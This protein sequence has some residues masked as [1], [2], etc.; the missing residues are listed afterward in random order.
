MTTGDIH[1]KT[2]LLR[3]LMLKADYEHMLYIFK[4]MNQN[5]IAL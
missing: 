3:F 1:D 5:F 2:S 4:Q